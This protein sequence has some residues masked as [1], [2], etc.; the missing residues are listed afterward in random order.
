RIRRIIFGHTCN[1]DARA[2]ARGLSVGAP[3]R[4]LLILPPGENDILRA[5]EKQYDA[6]I[7]PSGAVAA[8]ELGLVPSLPDVITFDTDKRIGPVQ[9]DN[10]T[11]CFNKVIDTKL[12]AVE[13][14]LLALL[15]AI[16]FVYARGDELPPLQQKR[17]SRLLRAY[18]TEQVFKAIE[19]WPRWFQE[20]VTHQLQ[21]LTKPYISGLSAFNIPHQSKQADWHQVGMLYSGKFQVVGKNYEGAPELSEDELFECGDFLAKFDVDVGTNLCATPARAI[22]DIL[23][24]SIISKTRYPGFFTL[25]QYM[26]ELPKHEIQAVIKDLEAMANEEQKKLLIEWGRDNALD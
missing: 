3:S 9:L 12:K 2:G 13:P 17:I 16:E 25:D 5:V 26:L 10:H 7:S 20:E 11:I 24:T 23:Y 14:L 21:T 4:A 1:A 15:K 8:F 6:R 18:S 22:K 19:L